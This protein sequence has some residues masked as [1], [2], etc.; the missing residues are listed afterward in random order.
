MATVAKAAAPPPHS[1]AASL[2]PATL[3]SVAHDFYV[4]RQENDPVFASDQGLHTGDERLT[5]Y[6]PA[7]LAERRAYVRRLLARIKA[8]KADGWP[9][10][11]RIDFILFRSQIDR[12]EFSDRVL[13]DL[14]QHN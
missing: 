2:T 11:D 14:R 7:A 8:T 3:R 4:W 6:S 10:D 5:D 9:K 1:K 12:D 13:R